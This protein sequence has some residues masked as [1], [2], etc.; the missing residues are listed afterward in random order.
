MVYQT[1]DKPIYEV[2]EK[3]HK[4]TPAGALVTG[5][6]LG[7]LAGLVIGT[8]CRKYENSLENKL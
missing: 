4:F 2:I 3:Y 6:A 8:A 5:A 7:L 1:T